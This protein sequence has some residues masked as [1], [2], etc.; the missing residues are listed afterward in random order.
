MAENEGQMTQASALSTETP[1]PER[2]LMAAPVLVQPAHSHRSA[3]L[4]ENPQPSSSAPLKRV[5]PD[6]WLASRFASGKTR[7]RLETLYAFVYEVA[8][9]AEAVSDPHLGLI[10]LAWWREALVD[11]VGGPDPLSQ[12]MRAMVDDIPLE[13]ALLNEMTLARS[14]DLEDVP[15]DGWADLEHYIDATAGATV[16]LAL[17]I[18]LAGQPWPKQAAECARAVGRA[19]GFTGLVRAEAAWRGRKRLF[20]PRRLLEHLRLTPAKAL[21]GGADH[22]MRQANLAMLDRARFAY[23]QAQDLA[24]VMPTAAFP[25]LGYVALEPG[26]RDQLQLGEARAERSLLSRQIKLVAASALGRF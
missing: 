17:Q 1:T 2:Q 11:G 12:A 8:R 25:A 15:F 23:G 21:E 9:T 4:A 18:C 16:H 5:D 14:K 26:Y 6:R 22:V 20:Y 10:R 13:A 24:R 7:A 3:V 19:W